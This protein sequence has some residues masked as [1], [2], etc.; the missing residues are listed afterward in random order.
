VN[1]PSPGDTTDA[2]QADVRADDAF[3]IFN[4]APLTA[5]ASTAKAS[6][7][8][9]LAGSIY[10]GDPE[11][12]NGVASYPV[13]LSEDAGGARAA[14]VTLSV[15]NGKV[16]GVETQLSEDWMSAHNTLEDGTVKLAMAGQG[17]LAGQQVAT[18]TVKTDG[19]ASD[20]EP[21]G[22]YRL[23]SSQAKDLEVRAAPDQFALN[24]SYPN[25]V[26]GGQATIEMDLPSRTSVTVEVYN[27]LGQRVQTIE[28][29]MAAGEAQSVQVDAS[30]LSSGQYFYRVNAELE[31]GST[32]TETRQMTVVR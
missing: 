17:S 18:V 5:A 2:E 24:G 9:G 31:D 29:S 19:D 15:D 25:P 22:E 13:M 4:S 1:T 6:T 12:E 28:Q 23:N 8:G 26:A 30:Q 21:G 3:T 32:V 20:V 11:V 10:L 14:D 7:G 27:V 16:T